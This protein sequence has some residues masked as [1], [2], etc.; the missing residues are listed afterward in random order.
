MSG[1][2]RTAAQ[3]PGE[4]IVEQGRFRFGPLRFTPSI[5]LTNLGVDNNVFNDDTNP[6][7]DT[8]AAIGPQADLWMHIGHSQFTGK[9]SGQYLYFGTYQNQRAFN[10]VDDGRWQW[11]MTRITPFLAGSYSNTKERPGY[12]ID[13]RARLRS[14]SFTVGTAVE[15]SAKTSVVVSGTR[16]RFAFDEGEL[17]LGADLASA[18][19]RTSDSGQLQLRYKLTTLTTFVVDGEAIQDRFTFNPL[20]DSTS[21]K[22]LPGF[23]LKPSAL[24]S[25]KVF[26]GYRQFT[27][28]DGAL[29][30]FSGVI[31]AVDAKYVMSSTRFAVKAS[32]DLAYSF[33][34]TQPYYALT[35][36]GLTVT[37]RVTRSWELVGRGGLQRL[38]YQQLRALESAGPRT[39]T[40]RQY[41]GGVGYRVGETIRLGFDAMYYERLSTEG[42][43]RG[44]DGLRFGASVSYGLPQ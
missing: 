1:A 39:D 20:R 21:V 19:N 32:R 11:R 28:R 36:L 27:A 12:E 13:S 33:E 3:A 8:T 35:D 26:V 24:I 7:Q 42:L 4:D 41:G 25:G 31:A 43:L 6:K 37:Q 29:S 15:L 17:F 34:P 38:A 2:A 23:E 16:T 22:V 9:V 44:F 40:I 14:D 10:T 30:D 18:L 5:A